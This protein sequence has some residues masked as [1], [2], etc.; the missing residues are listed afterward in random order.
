MK[1]TRAREA[2]T[3]NPVTTTGSVGI[4]VSIIGR[5]LGWDAQL[6]ADVAM[7]FLLAIPVVRGLVAWW[8]RRGS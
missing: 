6:Q 8:E 3:T 4:A 7:L 1:T 2:V 5:W